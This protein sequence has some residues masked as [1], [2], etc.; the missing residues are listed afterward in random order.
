MSISDFI[1]SLINKRRKKIEIN[2]PG[3]LGDFFRDGG[4]EIIYK[5]LELDNNSMVIDGGGYHGEFIDKILINF[6]CKVDSYEPLVN[7]FNKLEKKYF[8]NDKVK[9]YNQAIYSD[10]KELYLSQEGI[11]SSVITGSD[12]K[13]NLKIKAVDIIE[14]I[15]DKKIVDLLKLNVEG[16]EYEIMNRI[17]DSKNLDKF[18]SFLIQYHRS[19]ENCEELRKKIRKIL[20][21][22]NFKEIFNYDFVWE[23]WRR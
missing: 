2:Y 17:I 8:Y 20:L 12:A 3:A 23:Y 21:E 16:A 14:I 9:I 19:V 18:R 4:N 5:R 7:E 10:T 13:K 6:G 1:I 15:N 11:S 22:K